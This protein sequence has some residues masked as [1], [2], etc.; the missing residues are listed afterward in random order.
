MRA[1]DNRKPGG[2]IDGNLRLKVTLGIVLP[3]VL[4]LGTF[5]LIE[6]SRNHAILLDNLS[7]V[8][9]YN[10]QL[11]EDAL[12]RSMLESNFD[13]VQSTLDSVDKNQNFRVVYILD[14][15]GRVIFMPGKTNTPITL[16]NQAPAC[17]PCHRL[18]AADR[19]RS[20]VVNAEDGQRVFRSMQPIENSP[21]CSK[22]HDPGQKLI[23]LLLT[24]I[25][26][27]PFEAALAAD[28]RQN[29]VWWAGTI[30]ATAII[31]N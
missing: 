2:A 11:I 4:I 22:C 7:V 12:W 20:V 25:Y 15:S 27:A 5:T 8:A 30:L 19:P 9:S 6:N 13:D 31:V 3:L 28:L 17:Q 23:G 10:G 16:S 1:L 26:V 14:T 29:L 21:A 24:D 18:P